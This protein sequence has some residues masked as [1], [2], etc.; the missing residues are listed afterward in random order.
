MKRLIYFVI[1]LLLLGCKSNI[2]KIVSPEE[3]QKLLSQSYMLKP[4]SLL[5]TE[6]IVLKIKVEDFLITNI[7]FTDNHLQ[8]PVTREDL[9]SKEIPTFY[10]DILQ[11]QVY[12][13]NAVVDKWIK[14]GSR[15]AEDLHLY[16]SPE[17]DK[18]FYWNVERPRLISRLVESKIVTSYKFFIPDDLN[19]KQEI[20]ETHNAPKGFVCGYIVSDQQGYPYYSLFLVKGQNNY[21]LVLQKQG[22][23]KEIE[24]I[25]SYKAA[26]LIESVESNISTAEIEKQRADDNKKPNGVE[27]GN[28]V[29]ALQPG[30]LAECW[31]NDSKDIPDA[32]WLERYLFFNGNKMTLLPGNH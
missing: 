16:F 26:K 2:D 25:D 21:N 22:Q 4:D 11:Y 23:Q 3:Y 31:I 32:A 5:T 13:T 27:W 7:T 19:N 29:F 8:F 10:F 14:E 1:S 30:K 12:E 20:Y 15:T 17:E 6:D 18:D 28:K 24:H 9:E